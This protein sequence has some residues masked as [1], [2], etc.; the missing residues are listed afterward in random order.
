M[1]D[2]TASRSSRI[3]Q[4]KLPD[5]RD[6]SFKCVQFT[7]NTQCEFSL[8][9]YAR[10]RS[11]LLFFCFFSHGLLFLF[12]EVDF[13]RF[14]VYFLFSFLSPLLSFFL[15]SFFLLL[16]SIFRLYFFSYYS[17]PFFSFFF[18]L[19]FSPLFFPFSLFFFSFYAIFSSF[20]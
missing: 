5:F 17:L 10:L 20:F 16:P 4:D 2:L 3:I 15:T 11:S 6:R 13:F 9:A 14:I 19:I 18:L 8:K 7:N 1:F 12:S